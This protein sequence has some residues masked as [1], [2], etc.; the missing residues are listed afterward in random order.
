M[1]GLPRPARMQPLQNDV[2]GGCARV[3]KGMISGMIYTHGYTHY[4]TRAL[5]SPAEPVRRDRFVSPCSEIDL[6]P[7]LTLLRT[8]LTFTGHGTRH[9]HTEHTHSS[10]TNCA[11][12]DSRKG[13]RQTCQH[14]AEVQ[15]MRTTDRRLQFLPLHCTLRACSTLQCVQAALGVVEAAH[16]LTHRLR[17]QCAGGRRAEACCREAGRVGCTVGCG[18]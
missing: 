5:Q 15:N 6:R 18:L 3:W 13:T 1:P 14:T 16:R 9:T 2:V 4:R 11:L 7:H 10:D 17:T 12:S 8:S